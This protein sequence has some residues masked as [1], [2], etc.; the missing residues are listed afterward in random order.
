MKQFIRH[1]TA[2]LVLALF[3]NLFLA[4]FPSCAAEEYMGKTVTAIETAGC[5]NVSTSTVLGVIKLKPGETLTIE[6]VDEDTKAIQDLGYFSDVSVNF[7]LVPEGVKVIYTVLENS[8]ITDII[9][10]GATKVPVS[11]IIEFITNQPG[12]VVNNRTLRTNTVDI[13]EYYRE[14][15][16]ILAK[17]DDVSL[18]PGG[19]LQITI[20]E[21]ILEDFV[22]K[23]NTKTKEKIIRREMRVE[24]GQPF[25]VTQAR[26]SMRRIYNLG[27]FEDVNMKLN[28]GREPNAVVMQ[29]DVV[30][31]K[32]GV[33]TIGGGY[34]QN[35]GL[36][37]IIEVGDNN[38]LGR[39][40]RIKLHWEIGG[41]SNRNY[42]F[43]YQRPWLD[44]KGTSLGFSFFDMTNQFRDYYSG[45]STKAIYDRQRKGYN[46]TL[47]RPTSDTISNFITFKNRHDLFVRYIN[48]V[49]YSEDPNYMNN[50]FGLT[51]SITLS[52]VIDTRDN[53]TNPQS[54]TRTSF[55]AEFAGWLG[56]DFNFKKYIAENRKYFKVG[57]RQVVAFRLTGGLAHG[58]VSDANRFAIGGVD[59]VRGYRD[60]EFK[61][62]KMFA[63]TVEYR[64]PLVD[65]LEGVFFSDAGN[66]WSGPEYRRFGDFKFG[67]GAGIRIS[68]PIGPVRIDVAKGTKTQAVRTHFSFGGQF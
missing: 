28:P 29:V 31:Q 35:D 21:G 68:T 30:E 1:R 51:R 24:K 12:D 58:Q 15:G 13:R 45:G 34:S 10:Q 57:Q 36:I 32:T 59:T 11:K 53:F 38:F 62:D 42:E 55:S 65:K 23:G 63:A 8:V 39:G 49:N 40:D 48:G 9:I 41:A 56:G 60:D 16:Y 4:V 52:R 20:N 50:N 44:S 5:N 2:I 7:I 67:A 3:L 64:F 14:Q 25:N 26:A 33:F 27:F 37:G 61:G 19:I 66:A 46:I 43:S 17:V 22:I 6:K 47:G 54:G 18:R